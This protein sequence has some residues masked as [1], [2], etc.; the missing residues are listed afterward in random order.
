MAKSER[1]FRQFFWC[2]K[3]IAVDDGIIFQ[4]VFKVSETSGGYFDAINQD[5]KGYKTGR[6]CNVE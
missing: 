3:L 1:F 2:S 6:E 5:V 4:D